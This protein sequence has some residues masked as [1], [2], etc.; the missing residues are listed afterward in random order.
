MAGLRLNPQ[1]SMVRNYAEMLAAKII[2]WDVKGRDGKKLP[3]TADNICGLHPAF[4]RQLEA[5]VIEGR[6]LPS[7]ETQAEADTK[8]S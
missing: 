6:E 3:V 1:Q 5:A 4:Y 7:G 8:N 2:D